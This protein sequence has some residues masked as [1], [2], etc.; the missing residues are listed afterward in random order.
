MCMCHLFKFE[1]ITRLL[2]QRY[3]F[4]ALSS[5]KYTNKKWNNN[6]N[7]S[8][9][10]DKIRDNKM[11]DKWGCYRRLESWLDDGFRLMFRS[12]IQQLW[13][14]WS[15]DLFWG[16]S[17]VHNGLF[18]LTLFCLHC[19]KH[20]ANQSSSVL[21]LSNKR[22]DFQR[23]RDITTCVKKESSNVFKNTILPAWVLNPSIHLLLW[24]HYRHHRK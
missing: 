21:K 9:I 7:N 1:T 22:R 3:L 12:I 4:K 24:K 11:S 2:V 18:T 14:V 5:A 19:H 6:W 20:S 17:W 16:R 10:K 23:Q 8:Y 15:L 13:G